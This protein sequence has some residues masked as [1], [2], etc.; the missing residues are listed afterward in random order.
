M[1]LLTI[2]P[3]AVWPSKPLFSYG[4]EFGQA[5]GLLDP[6]DWITSI[7]VTFP[8]EAFIN[9]GWIGFMP[10]VLIGVM[11][12]LIYRAHQCWR[13]EQTGMLLYAITLPTILYIGGTFALFMG[14]LMKLL[15]LYSLIGW[16]MRRTTIR[17][18][19]GTSSS[20]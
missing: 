5:A 6:D 1:V 3:R 16:L 9:F 2:L 12:S 19:A 8:G 4:T 14:G 13:Q 18:T 15:L 11:Y 7:S 10:F 17:S 20:C